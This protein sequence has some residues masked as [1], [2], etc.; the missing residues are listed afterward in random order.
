MILALKIVGMLM[1]IIGVAAVIINMIRADPP[2]TIME[3]QEEVDEETKERI[4][5]MKEEM[6]KD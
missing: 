4:T 5:E 6:K 2:F 3:K 1:C